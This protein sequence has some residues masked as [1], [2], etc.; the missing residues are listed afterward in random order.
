LDIESQVDEDYCTD[1]DKNDEK[2]AAFTQ[3]LQSTL[4][5]QDADMVP[6]EFPASEVWCQSY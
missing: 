2:L 6:D 4:N 1:K 3:T 5:D